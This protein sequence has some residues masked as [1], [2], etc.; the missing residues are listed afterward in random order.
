[1]EK[2]NSIHE[3]EG[4]FTFFKGLPEYYSI[5]RVNLLISG[6]IKSVKFR[7]KWWKNSLNILI[8]T[9]L[10]SSIIVGWIVFY[11]NKV[12]VV[13]IAEIAQFNKEIALAKNENGPSRSF[14]PEQYKKDDGV[15]TTRNDAKGALD[16]HLSESVMDGNK[17]I[18]DLNPNELNR[19]GFDCYYHLVYYRNVSPHHPVLFFTE[20]VFPLIDRKQENPVKMPELTPNQLQ[21]DSFPLDLKFMFYE[22][23]APE[24]FSITKMGRNRPVPKVLRTNSNNFYP[25]FITGLDGTEQSL[26]PGKQLSECADTLVPVVVRFSRLNCQQKTD[27]L[28][29]FTA[30]PDLFKAL[31][32]H[33]RWIESQV[34]QLKTLK[35]QCPDK[36]LVDYD[37]D[38][39]I[40]QQLWPSDT[41]I[42]A[43]DWIAALTQPELEKI[44]L[45]LSDDSIYH[46][47]YSAPAGIDCGVPIVQ[48]TDSGIYY[49][50]PKTFYTDFLIEA[51]T[52]ENGQFAQQ[53]TSAGEMDKFLVQ[54]DILFPVKVKLFGTNYIYWFTITDSL[55]SCLPDRY[56]RLKEK[57]DRLLFLKS[58]YPNN[59][60]VQYFNEIFGIDVSKVTLLELNKTEL[61]TL[62][63]DF[64]SD[65]VVFHGFNN[66]QFETYR[67][68]KF[69]EPDFSSFRGQSNPPMVMKTSEKTDVINLDGTSYL[70][71]APYNP[72]YLSKLN[73]NNNLTFL[74]LTDVKGRS[75]QFLRFYDNNYTNTDWS[76]LIPIKTKFSDDFHNSAEDR[77]FWFVASEQ[78][79]NQLPDRY[80]VELKKEF[81]AF[82]T[83]KTNPLSPGSCNYL[84]ECRSTLKIKNCRMYPNPAKESCTL[85]LNTD[86]PFTGTIIVA[87]IAGSIVRQLVENYSFQVGNNNVQLD[88]LEL[89]SG[90]YLLM[91]S[92]ENGFYTTRLIIQ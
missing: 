89:N 58:F 1:M 67:L 84:E 22:F 29:W 80:R 48:Q 24:I 31:P 10:I 15:L 28:F 69:E 46:Y 8:L 11:P 43:A 71:G 2:N 86:H 7:Y 40:K 65:S 25:V 56:L 73:K 72:E 38:R 90:I 51:Y 60:N 37:I 83:D 66:N 91:I 34:N 49:R 53:T 41:T 57:Y 50:Y 54:N 20:K 33:Y 18:V 92:A 27:M 35:K 9:I 19:L 68:L 6:P 4:F 64:Q 77:I 55:W 76:H 74:L 36:H 88:L 45:I 81:Q 85:E 44:G 17:M 12:K 63:F 23:R 52:N 16:Q 47:H 13:P 59:D 26:I 14:S 79:I 21:K 62:G 75:V 78:L 3:V 39:W 30:T 5:E 87:N 61:E 32:D 70:T 42:F 82:P